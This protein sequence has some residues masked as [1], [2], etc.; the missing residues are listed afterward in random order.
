MIQ[1]VSLLTVVSLS[2]AASFAEREAP[3]APSE[4]ISCTNFNLIAEDDDP[5]SDK[6]VC[7][8]HPPPLPHLTRAAVLT[9]CTRSCAPSLVS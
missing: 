3:I 2:A 6:K 4:I 5:R 7:V 8:A 9:A 1:H